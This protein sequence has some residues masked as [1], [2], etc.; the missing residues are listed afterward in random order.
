MKKLVLGCALI[1]SSSVAHGQEPW[2]LFWLSHGMHQGMTEAE[3]E[4]IA[5]DSQFTVKPLTEGSNTKVVETGEKVYWIAFCEGKLTYASWSFHTNDEFI[6][7]MDERVN[8]QGFRLADYRV[9]SYYNDASAK[10]LNQFTLR[11]ESSSREYSV[12][13]NLFSD[14]GQVV[15]EDKALDETVSCRRESP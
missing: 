11:F 9:S 7:S 6:K 8:S 5:N 13:Y 14:N 12:T 4:K 2:N 15:V 10:E 1:C 3:F